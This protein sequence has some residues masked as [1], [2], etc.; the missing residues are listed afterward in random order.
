MK[1]SGEAWLKWDRAIL[2]LGDKDEGRPKRVVG[3][4]MQVCDEETGKRDLLGAVSRGYVVR[5]W[6][7][8][9]EY[10]NAC[11]VSASTVVRGGGG[12]W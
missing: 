1:T 8:P 7:E 9:N 6:R 5:W 2:R 10:F 4:K 11:R 12:R 3:G